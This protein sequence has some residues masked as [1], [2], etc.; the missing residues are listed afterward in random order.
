M[1][2]PC[3][4]YDD[5][6]RIQSIWFESENAGG[7]SIDPRYDQ[8]TSKIIAYADNGQMAPVPFYAVYDLEGNIKARVPAH[9]VTVVYETQDKVE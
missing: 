1:S 4:I 7:Y 5:K 2:D 9:M 8:T 3:L 6:R